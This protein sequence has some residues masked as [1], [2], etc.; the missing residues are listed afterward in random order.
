MKKTLTIIAL[1]VAGT[2]AQA[3]LTLDW[4]FTTTGDV[5]DGSG[6]LTID[7]NLTTVDGYSGY[8][9]TAF[10]GTYL[11]DTITG[12]GPLSG[13]G[14]GG[15]DDL[16]S[17]LTGNPGNTDANDQLDYEGITFAYNS[18]SGTA[19]EKYRQVPY[20]INQGIPYPDLEVANG[21]N[22]TFSAVETAPEPG[23][24]ALAGLGIAG[25][26]ALRRNK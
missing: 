21:N 13:V 23:S 25:W 19:Y 6:T 8:Q 15:A 1:A 18:D 22:G 26:F 14:L 2:A 24:T 10:S 3:D 9:I 11:G 16:I 7:P 20:R 4:T 17:N 5:I 12:L